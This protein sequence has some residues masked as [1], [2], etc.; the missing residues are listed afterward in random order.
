MGFHRLVVPVYAGGLR[1]GDDYINNAVAGT[2]APA[3]G[4]LGAGLY[5]GSYFFA[6]SDQVTGTALNRGLKA[7]AANTDFLDNAIVQMA[8]D[9][10]AADTAQNVA[11][12]NTAPAGDLLIG[13][14]AKPV[15]FTGAPFSLALGTVAT[16]LTALLGRL[17]DDERVRII[18]VNATVD[19]GGFRDKTIVINAFNLTVTLPDP[20]VNK[21]REIRLVSTTMA[22]AMH[23]APDGAEKINGVA[24]TFELPDGFAC[25]VISN[26]VDWFV[27]QGERRR[28]HIEVQTYASAESAV[29]AQNEIFE[30]DTTG[31]VASIQLPPLNTDEHTGRRIYIKDIGGALSTNPLTILRDG[32]DTIEGV[33]SNFVFEAD[34]GSLTLWASTSGWWFL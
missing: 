11:L 18:A 26:G 3:D 4:A 8:L 31:G 5:A 34:Y 16:Q 33:A 22:T 25:S 28:L 32:T 30:V 27:I 24:A 1:G 19:D 15:S 20:T 9:Y 13:S 23:L 21:G 12:A 14:A 10:V 6:Q 7:L 2:P 29:P 17:N